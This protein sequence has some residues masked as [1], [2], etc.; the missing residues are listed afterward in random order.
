MSAR[1]RTSLSRIAFLLL[2]ALGV[3]ARAV[4][5][6]RG[7]NFDFDSFVIVAGITRNGGNVYA[8]TSRYNYGPV[9]FT[10][11]HVLDW[12]SFSVAGRASLFRPLLVGLLT[13]TDI[14][15]ALLLRGAFGL[16]PALLFFLSPVTVIITGYHNQFDNLAL[17]L[18][19][20]AASLYGNDEDGRAIGRK[21]IGLVVL[22]AS[23]ATKHI[24]FAFPAWLAFRERTWAG[25]ATAVAVPGLVF[26]AGFA[27]FWSR[28]SHGIIDNVF[29]YKSFD[30]AP[31]FQLFVPPVVSTF[32]SSRLLFV[33]GLVTLGFAVRRR[34]LLDAA[35]LY[36]MAVVALSP[37]VANQYLAIPSA[38]VAAN[39]NVPFLLFILCSTLLLLGNGD[40]LHLGVARTLL[41]AGLLNSYVPEIFLLSLGLVCVLWGSSMRDGLGRAAGAVA[42]RLRGAHGS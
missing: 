13:T 25:R 12:I 4:A 29:R 19:L 11:L 9:W 42:R 7:H 36:S 31:F 26:V 5:A 41:P 38:G 6:T 8:E 1:H 22:G 40:G 28:G 32:V 3:V 33:A 39:A 15:I 35:L 30:N 10:I 37:A 16:V 21:V 18:A 23:L 27:P 14:A 20:V 24:F 34:P 2:L 17:L